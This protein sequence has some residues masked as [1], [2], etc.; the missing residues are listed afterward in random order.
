MAE[1]IACFVYMLLY[2]KKKP[3]LIMFAIFASFGVLALVFFFIIK[4][5]M[6]GSFIEILTEFRF[7]DLNGRKDIYNGFLQ[8][9]EQNR[10]L[11][12]GF[13]GSFNFVGDPVH[14]YSFCH[15]SIF[16]MMLVAGNI[17]LA[18]LLLHWILK[19]GQ[20]VM[21]ITKEKFILLLIFL[22]PGL[23]GLVDVT[24]FVPVYMVF[25][26]MSYITVDDI[27]NDTKEAN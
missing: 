22:A 16:Q 11:G 27:L 25:L 14:P 26:F 10:M 6:F 3:T 19:Y 2:S 24:Y 1:F 8:V 7:T 23:Y 12:V 18:C 21:N 20:L 15:S 13:I 4:P 17:G 9:Y 5:E